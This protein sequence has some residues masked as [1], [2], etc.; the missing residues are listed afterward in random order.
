MRLPPTRPSRALPPRALRPPLRAGALVAAALVAASLAAPAQAD[1]EGPANQ[2]HY[3]LNDELEGILAAADAARA[4]G[5]HARAIDLYRGALESDGPKGKAG[6]L[7]G[8]YQIARDPEAR[9]QRRFIGITE[10]AIRGL[11]ALPPEG[12]KLFRARYD[13]R[14]GSALEA[15]LESDEPFRALARA[16]E[17][18]PV[19]SHAPRMLEALA[20]L[21][22]ERGEL[23]RARRTLERL[24]EH[25]EAEIAS[26]PAV[27]KKLLVCAIG[28]GDPVGVQRWAQ[29]LR[30]DAP[31]RP[32]HLGGEPLAV[33]D[34]IGRAL[35]VESARGAAGAVPLVR[36]D[37]QNH[38]YFPVEAAVGA[39]RFTPRAFDAAGPA[40]GFGGHPLGPGALQGGFGSHSR[41]LPV[42]HDGRAFVVTADS[43]HAFDLANGDEARRIRR[44]PQRP[45]Y[46]DPNPKVQFGGAIARGVLAAPLVQEVLRDQTFRGIPI[47][48]QIPIRKLAGFDVDPERWSWEWDHA[49]MLRDTALERW[50]FPS[51]P[52]ALEGTIYASAFA[53]EGFVD[54]HVAAFDARTGR[55]I[56]T[57]W[58][59][60][61]QVEQTM[62][63]E[64]ANEPLC[65][66][67]AAA[68][69]VIYYCTSFGS[70]AALDA[71][72]GRMLWV[73]E[74]DQVE[75]HAPKGYY[76]TMRPIVWENNAPVIERGVVVV[77]PLDSNEVYGFDA[78]TG[79]RLWEADARSKGSSQVDMRYVFGAHAG[80]VV[81]AGGHEVRCHDV[82]GGKLLWSSQ[83]R[84]RVIAGRGL[85]AGG[86]VL[87]PLD[88]EKLITIDLESGERTGMHDLAATGNLTLSG[89]ALLVVGAGKLVAH[90]N[91]GQPAGRSF[92]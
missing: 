25:H 66:P 91:G 17:Q 44:P 65:V 33:E 35:R 47:K 68:D 70:L 11:R 63:G 37:A 83:L 55:P 40:R 72:T 73:A 32:I 54:C 75:V 84:G 10:W 24:L 79:E 38:A 18:F 26:P 48:V 67:V 36:G 88:N 82:A 14:A 90:K 46:D 42:V 16:Y 56:W 21:A 89:D 6:E 22:L 39:A 23:A 64:Q 76:A 69:G 15:A 31:G 41:A 2:I 30:R 20:E 53:I 57:T 74:Y 78:R 71:D 80:R 28:L 13:Y 92:K 87:A 77:A 59:A 27:R 12:L 29:A 9:G 86:A 50:S 61:G 43:V 85:I 45:L 81:L 34:L 49:L 4:E 5:E 8:G 52:T 62:F 7:K 1:D 60:S 3:P 51:P 19:S 58:V